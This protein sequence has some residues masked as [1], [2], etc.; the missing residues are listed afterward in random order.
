M[1]FELF[2]GGIVHLICARESRAHH[3]LSLLHVMHSL[4]NGHRLCA[5]AQLADGKLADVWPWPVL[6]AITDVV[7]LHHPRSFA[8]LLMV[9]PSTTRSE[10]N[11][12]QGQ[13]RQDMLKKCSNTRLLG[14]SPAYRLEIKST[15]EHGCL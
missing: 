15:T 5:T 11:N 4:R 9:Q 12:D 3:F 6:H 8:L 13:S 7:Y 14:R 10:L 2:D 1:N